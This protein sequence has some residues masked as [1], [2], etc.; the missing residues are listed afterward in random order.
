M[1]V[2]GSI[3]AVQLNVDYRAEDRTKETFSESDF[4]LGF[5]T[6]EPISDTKLA[7]TIQ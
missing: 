4:D 5:G 2:I 1:T 6:F 7:N 3:A